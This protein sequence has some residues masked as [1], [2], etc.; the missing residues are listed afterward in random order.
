MEC[1]FDNAATTMPHRQ[2]ADYLYEAMLNNYANPSSLHKKA[3]EAKKYIDYATPQILQVLNLTG[4]KV[5]YT[6][7]ATE[8]ANL[9]IKGTLEKYDDLSKNHIITTLIEHPCVSEVFEYYEGKGISVSYIPVDQFG[10]INED[11]LLSAIRPNTRLISLIWV[12]NEFGSVQPLSKLIPKIRDVSPGILIHIDAVQGYGKILDDLSD[13]DMISISA[14]KFHGPKGIGALIIKKNITLFPQILGGGQQENIRSGTINAPMIGALGK[15]CEMISFDAI[16]HIKQLQTYLFQ[17]LRNKYGD[18]LFNTKL[19][20]SNYAP[21]IMNI[22]F[23]G[24]KGEVIL[25]MLEE[26]GIYL[27]TASACSSHKK[28]KN[29]V[30]KQI[31]RTAKEIDGTIRLSLSEYNTKDEIDYFLEK[32]SVITEKLSRFKKG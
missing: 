4:R 25:H 2:V 12:N 23:S 5:I 26:D 6:S 20:S 7:G 29:S 10:Q 28:N 24:L 30:L 3:L 22:S 11:F 9:A 8:S 13:A 32:L 15:A 27:S 14:H 18:E 16:E 19:E 1:Y 31:G 17:N 21:H